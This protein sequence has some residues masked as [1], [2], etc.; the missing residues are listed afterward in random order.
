MVI[1]GVAMLEELHMSR[2]HPEAYAPYR[3]SAPFLLPLPAFVGRLV[4]IPLR[5]LF[6]RDRP[7]RRREVVFVISFYTALLMAA[8]VLLYGGGIR[9]LAGRV[10]PYQWQMASVNQLVNEIRQETNP[11]RKWSLMDQLAQSGD[12]AIEPMLRLLKDGTPELRVLTAE[13]VAGMRSDRILPALLAALTDPVG[14]VRYRALR[15]LSGVCNRECVALVVPLLDDREAH[16][17]IEA[18]RLLADLGSPAMMDLA[19]TLLASPQKWQRAAAADALGALGSSD[20]VS[21]L[22]VKRDDSEPAV[23]QSVVIA[24][25]RSGS[26]EARA[27]L[28]AA[29]QDP[30]WEVRV[31]AAEALKR[32]PGNLKVA[33]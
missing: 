5:I 10:L 9:S 28:E 8:S 19:T 3:R 1:I 22:A 13:R 27:A 20:T 17:R 26:P 21:V 6:K 25:L 31:Y 18:M 24:L 4:A 32:I 2:R 11:R 12:A 16:I 23:R 15:G 30:D 33:R 29:S 14:D 7:E